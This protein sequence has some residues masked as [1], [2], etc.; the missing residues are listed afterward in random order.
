MVVLVLLLVLQA[1]LDPQVDGLPQRVAL[2]LGLL[3]LGGVLADQDLL[4]LE[5]RVHCGKE[6]GD[7][8][9]LL[10]KQGVSGHLY[11]VYIAHCT[12]LMPC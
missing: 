11:T 1:G 12:I 2:P 10:H 8:Q 3:V 6:R 4:D 9:N 5:G 7:G